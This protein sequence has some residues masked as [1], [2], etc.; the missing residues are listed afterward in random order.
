VTKTDQDTETDTEFGRAFAAA[1]ERH[2]RSQTSVAE[3]L[4]TSRAYVSALRTGSKNATASTVDRVADALN[5]AETERVELHR[6]A[7]KD[8]GFKLD[9]P[10]DF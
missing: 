9:L 5:L 2:G 10:D 4:G 8:A 3:S 7:A 1:L 6:A